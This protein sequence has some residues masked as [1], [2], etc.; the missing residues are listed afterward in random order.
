MAAEAMAAEATGLRRQGV[1]HS[2]GSLD[3]DALNEL[4]CSS[5]FYCTP[6]HL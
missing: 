2:I 5:E 1:C 4:Q 6:M 3:P